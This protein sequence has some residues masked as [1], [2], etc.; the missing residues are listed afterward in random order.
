MKKRISKRYLNKK[1]SHSKLLLR[2]LLLS[3]LQHGRIETVLAKAKILK[4]YTDQELSYCI[5]GNRVQDPKM[6]EK[7]YGSKKTSKDMI[8]FCEFLKKNFPGMNSGFTSI[9]RTRNRDGDN[10]VM[11]EISLIGFDKY[12]KSLKPVK[13]KKK[14]AKKVVSKKKQ[15]VKKK[16][17][18]EKKS[19]SA[20]EV[21]KKKFEDAA[22]SKDR[23]VEARRGLL[24]RLK[25]RILGRKVEDPNAQRQRRSRARSGI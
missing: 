6:I 9:V 17:I 22:D 5:S 16:K 8:N 24:S 3:L 13:S 18:E 4:S 10:S 7:R 15:T 20:K 23:G 19:E 21:S 14:A 25:G 2:S 11:A 12:V 1:K